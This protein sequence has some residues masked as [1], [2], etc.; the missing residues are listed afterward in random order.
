MWCALQRV[1]PLKSWRWM[2]RSCFHGGNSLSRQYSR[3]R[4]LAVRSCRRP[5]G[6]SA[7]SARRCSRPCSDRVM[8]PGGTEPVPHW[9]PNTEKGC[10]WCCGSILRHLLGCRGKR[11]TTQWLAAMYVAGISWYGMFRLP[12]LCRRLSRPLQGHLP[13][14]HRLRPALLSRLVCRTWPGSLPGPA[15]APGV[16]Y[17]VDAGGP[18]IQALDGLP[19]LFGHR[20]VLPDLRHRRRPGPLAS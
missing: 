1:R 11:C 18:P 13:R 8:L 10:A 20:R 9:Q 14:P 19:A 6:R 16:V 17:P 7:R 12:R 3:R 2:L 15:P 4:W 5:S